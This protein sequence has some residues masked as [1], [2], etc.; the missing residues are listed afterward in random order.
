MSVNL[1]QLWPAAVQTGPLRCGMREK[2][3]QGKSNEDGED[4]GASDERCVL[5]FLPK[6]VS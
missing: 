5:V 2:Q 4:E 1:R 6:E 3:S